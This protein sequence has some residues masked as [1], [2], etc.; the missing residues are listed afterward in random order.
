[1]DLFLSKLLPIF[2]YPLGLACVL[3]ITAL[4][5]S[6]RRCLQRIVLILALLLLWLAS[7]RW[8]ALGLARSL[9]WQ[10]LPPAE[11]PH[12]EAVVLLGGGTLPAEPPRQM[13]EL[14]GSGDRVLYAAWLYRQGKVEHILLS[15]GLLDWEAGKS[16]PAQDMASLLEMMGVPADVL[17]L[18]TESRNTFEDAV[19][20]ARLLKS[21]GVRSVLL[22]TSAWHMPRAV[23]FFQFQGVEVVPLPVDFTVTEAGWEQLT[24]GDLRAK[25]LA[26]M[27][28]AD[29]LALTSHMLKERLGMLVYHAWF[30][31]TKGVK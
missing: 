23:E 26:L 17:W 12:A 6:K 28:T 24:R 2:V 14:N 4:A 3:I 8:I 13:V 22:V 1:M 9:E 29:N 10:Y 31:R 18:Q 16:T 7:N 15:G 25:V 27:P 20:S 30:S 21:K 11:I 19:Y 5:L